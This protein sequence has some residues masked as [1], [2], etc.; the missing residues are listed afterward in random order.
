MEED[1]E[2]QMSESKK[3]GSGK[4]NQSLIEENKEQGCDGYATHF[5][6]EKLT[7]VTECFGKQDIISGVHCC[8]IY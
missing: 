3:I 1:K 2:E 8:C 4:I 5:L 6:S 7:S